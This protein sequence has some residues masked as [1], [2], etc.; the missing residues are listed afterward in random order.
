M[1]ASKDKLIV[2]FDKMVSYPANMDSQSILMKNL[3]AE[4]L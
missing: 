4:P 1:N 3:G 2:R